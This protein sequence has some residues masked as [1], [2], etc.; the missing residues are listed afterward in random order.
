MLEIFIND[1]D[2]YIHISLNNYLKEKHG[3]YCSFF[4][5]QVIYFIIYV[6][7]NC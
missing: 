7:G 2:T 6:V 5:I 3:L 1:L 4:L